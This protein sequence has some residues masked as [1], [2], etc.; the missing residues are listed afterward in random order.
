MGS[1]NHFMR[2]LYVNRLKEEGFRVTRLKEPN[3]GAGTYQ[4]AETP[5]EPGDF[6]TGVVSKVFRFKGTLK[7]EYMNELEPP[8]YRRSKVPNYQVS[9]ITFKKDFTTIFE[10]GFYM[11]QTSVFMDGYL[12]WAEKIGELMPLSYYPTITKE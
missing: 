3:V 8:E 6:L 7:I 5:V 11:E 4:G 9:F 2:A 12:G 1:M 10:N